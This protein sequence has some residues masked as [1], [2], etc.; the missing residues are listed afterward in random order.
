[1]TKRARILLGGLVL[2]LL[3]AYIGVYIYSI[4]LPKKGSSD[5]WS[6]TWDG[7]GEPRVIGVNPN[8]PATSLQIGDEFIAINGVKIKDDPSLLGI[9]LRVPPGTRY[10][11]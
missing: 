9:G 2:T 4:T 7:R 1:M 11:L 8:G 5:G 6:V 10:T 3:T